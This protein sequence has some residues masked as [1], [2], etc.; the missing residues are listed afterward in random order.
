MIMSDGLQVSLY[1]TLYF[2]IC[3]KISILKT[4][5]ETCQ[6]FNKSCN[7]H[8]VTYDSIPYASHYVEV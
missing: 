1:C 7:K 6:K 5:L 4:I 2:C 8:L 3:L